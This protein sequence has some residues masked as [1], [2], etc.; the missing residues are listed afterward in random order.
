MKPGSAKTHNSPVDVDPRVLRH[1]FV[2]GLLFGLRVV[3][4]ILSVL[5]GLIVALGLVVGLREGWSVQ[6][7]IY[8]SFVSGL[9]IGYGDLAPKTLLTRAL[10]VLIGMCG[11]LL[12]ALLAAIAVKALTVARSGSD[13]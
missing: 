2:V 9:T 8:F 4:P 3:W 7:S 5:L 12:T 1:R 10:A 11:V 6:E 13:E